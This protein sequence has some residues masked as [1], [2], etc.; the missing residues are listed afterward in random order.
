MEVMGGGGG[1]CGL[2]RVGGFFQ[3]TL[4]LTSQAANTGENWYIVQGVDLRSGD[5]ERGQC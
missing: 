4:E 5:S 2:V 3:R 1:P